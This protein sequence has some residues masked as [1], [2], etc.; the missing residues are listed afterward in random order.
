MLWYERMCTKP[1]KKKKKKKK[2]SHCEYLIIL[3]SNRGSGFTVVISCLDSLNPLCHQDY[4][5]IPPPAEW[6]AGAGNAL[7]TAKHKT[8][9]SCGHVRYQGHE[10]L[11]HKWTPKCTVSR[12]FID[13]EK[14]CWSIVG[15]SL[16]L[17][18]V[19]WRGER[20]RAREGGRERIFT[21]LPSLLWLLVS[22]RRAYY[23]WQREL[24]MAECLSWVLT[25]SREYRSDLQLP[26]SRIRMK[27]PVSNFLSAPFHPSLR[28][29]PICP[30]FFYPSYLLREGDVL[31]VCACYALG[32]KWLL[33]RKVWGRKL[34]QTTSS[35]T[36]PF[37]C[38]SLTYHSR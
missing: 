31:C 27:T 30:H 16:M 9:S 24:I 22:H 35:A 3:V 7:F 14:A 20:E 4:I 10:L 18:D 28:L 8:T 34:S 6:S 5:I 38:S 1:Q 17:L 29:P 2:K 33:K 15:P 21:F 13:F 37:P 32:E 25:R 12:L 11:K 26:P 23:M 19:L 36:S